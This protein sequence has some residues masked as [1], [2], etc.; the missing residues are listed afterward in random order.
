M[1]SEASRPPIP[2]PILIKEGINNF[3]KKLKILQSPTKT[4]PFLPLTHYKFI[5]SDEEKNIQYWNEIATEFVKQKYNTNTSYQEFPIK[6]Y[7]GEPPHELFFIVCI[8]Q[9]TI[10]IGP[11]KKLVVLYMI[12]DL[13]FLDW[14]SI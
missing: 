7:T 5:Q 9:G 1:L 10:V 3:K 14:K 13:A 12:R 8:L 4:I 11:T 2:E 6:I